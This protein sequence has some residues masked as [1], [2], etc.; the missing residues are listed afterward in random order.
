VIGKGQICLPEKIARAHDQRQP[1][2]TDELAAIADLN[3]STQRDFSTMPTVPGS[4]ISCAA[5]R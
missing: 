1:E 4:M 2:R 5:L 3:N